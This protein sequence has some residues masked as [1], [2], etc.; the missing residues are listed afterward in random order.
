[1]IGPTGAVRVMAATRPVDFRNGAEGLAALVREMM[2]VD[3]FDGAIYVF[4]VKLEA[5]D[6]SPKRYSPVSNL[7][8]Q[9][10]HHEPATT[11][12]EP[13]RSAT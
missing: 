6:L 11:I 9:T 3:P 4:R 10:C 12:V 13:W 2:Q 1:M 5:S 7:C 8:G